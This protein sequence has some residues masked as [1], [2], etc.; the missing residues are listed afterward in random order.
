MLLRPHQGDSGIIPGNLT[1]VFQVAKKTEH[2]TPTAVRI[3][4]ITV[5]DA[6]R[7]LSK[8]YS[9]RVTEEQVC[10]VAEAGGLVKADGTINLLEY[11]AYLVGE[12]AH[13]SD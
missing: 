11:T 9:R 6:A 5:A 8:A 10:R 12:L 7:V 13:G 3:T 2:E 1:E 4:A